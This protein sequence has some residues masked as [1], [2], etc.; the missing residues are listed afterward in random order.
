MV[1]FFED[2]FGGWSRLAGQLGP[3]NLTLNGC[4]LPRADLVPQFLDSIVESCRE[5]GKLIILN[6]VR[7]SPCSC[8]IGATLPSRPVSYRELVSALRDLG[9]IP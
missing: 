9:L 6:L 1:W 3:S 4:A 2:G 5:S 7:F 8:F